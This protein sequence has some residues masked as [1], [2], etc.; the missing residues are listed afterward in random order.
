M[1]K[2]IGI[3]GGSFDPIHFG[4]LN[5]A[6]E[7]M[8]AHQLD[9]V[10]FCPVA[11]S[12]HKSR[13]APVSSEHRLNMLRLAIENEPRFFISEIEI[14]RD[15][16]SYTIETLKA[17]IARQE[18]CEDPDTFALILGEDSAENFHRW[19]QPEEIVKLARL[20]IG[21]RLDSGKKTAG[22]KGDPSVV[23]AIKKG[24][25][26]TRVMEISSKEIRKRLLNKKYCYHLIPGKVMDYINTNHLYCYVLNEVR[27][28]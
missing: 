3:Y 25:T 12:P 24:L 9:E 14:E 6:T 5:L 16:L 17:L 7:M 4:H 22:F 11:C 1:G 28:L 26:K 8:E 10:W 13:K 18:N 15:G 19:L 21:C 2:L 23:E 20:L 27:F